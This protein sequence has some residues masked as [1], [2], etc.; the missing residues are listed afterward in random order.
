MSGD[1]PR[2]WDH[3]VGRLRPTT[4]H[5]KESE[6]REQERRPWSCDSYVAQR[7]ATAA[8]GL[9][10]GKNSDR[11]AGE[12]QPLRLIPAREKGDALQLAYASIPDEP[13]YAHLGAAPFWC[14]GCEFGVNEHDVAIGNEAQFTRSWAENVQHAGNGNSPAGGILG[15]ELVR[16]GL[17]RGRSA[18]AALDVMTSLLERHGQWGSR[19]FGKDPVEGSYDNSYLIA[20]PYDA[21]VLETCGREW[22]A[23]QIRSGICS[24]SNEPSIRTEYDLCSAGLL[25]TAQARGWTSPDAPFDYASAIPI[26]GHR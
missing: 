17:E 3:A 11:P 21:W 9:I 18:R 4:G 20:D 7:D 19:L 2:T 5:G 1:G 8:G 10:F 24:I 14:W 6:H 12:A 15:I 25:A 23:R 13:A 26:P 16:L 22:V